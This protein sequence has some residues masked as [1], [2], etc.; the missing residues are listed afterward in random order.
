LLQRVQ[1]RVENGVFNA[2]RDAVGVKDNRS[3]YY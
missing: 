1:G 2:L 3:L